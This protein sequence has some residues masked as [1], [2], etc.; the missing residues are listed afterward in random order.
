MLKDDLEIALITYNRINNLKETLSMLFSDNSP[1]KD[2]QI[3]I[4][5]N[6]SDDGTAELCKKYT[7]KY[8]NLKY[9]C[10]NRNIGGNANTARA[11]EL[12]TKKYLWILCDDDTYE[13]SHFNEIEQAI[14]DDNDLIFTILGESGKINNIADIFYM[15][16]FAPA[17]ICK[18]S[19]ITSSVMDNI[20]FN[21]SNFFPHLCVISKILNDNK[22]IYCPSHSTVLR[23]T[24][25][26]NAQTFVRGVNNKDIAPLRKGMFWL[27]GY[28]TSVQMIEDKHKRDF[29]IDNLRYAH[30]SLF[31]LF[32]S[33]IFLNK[34]CYNN[35]LWNLTTIF[36]GLN[37]RQKLLFLK[38]LI[39]VQIDSVFIKQHLNKP[40][41]KEEWINYFELVD[42]EKKL[43]QLL[44]KYKN[45]RVIIYGLGLIANILLEKYNLS[46]FNIV[47]VADRKFKQGDKFLKYDG[48]SMQDIPQYC[49]DVIFICNYQDA[50]IKKALRKANIAVKTEHILKKSTQIYISKL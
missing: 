6:H 50:H 46:H 7:Q 5:D 10:H 40:N 45:K 11:F 2:L 27:A 32:K 8:E 43:G 25:N 26:D 39:A 49:P 24:A 12:A 47:A 20:M 42:Q 36:L 23:G 33:N 35:S 22:K 34:F 13:W 16:A 37:F 29:I 4:L 21:I 38:A 44:K 19:N 14:K 48:I 15:G 30:N 31:D 9:I 17:F 1:V 28:I 41:S 18:T 3:T